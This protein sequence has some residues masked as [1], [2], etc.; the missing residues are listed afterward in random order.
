M[1]LLLGAFNMNF[2]LPLY[3]SVWLPSDL[4]DRRLCSHL[5]QRAAF[6]GL[7]KREIFALLEVPFFGWDANVNS[8]LPIHRGQTSRR[9]KDFMIVFFKQ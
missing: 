2:W 8:L 6:G 9:A 1:I 4:W 3:L 7:Y 5:T